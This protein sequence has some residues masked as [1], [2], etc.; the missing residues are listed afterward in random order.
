MIFFRPAHG[1]DACARQGARLA[2]NWS[3]VH[4]SRPV[5]GIKGVAAGLLS[6]PA[7]WSVYSTSMAAELP[8]ASLG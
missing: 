4:F 3:Q 2:N 8:I 7:A 1:G 6:P 5:T